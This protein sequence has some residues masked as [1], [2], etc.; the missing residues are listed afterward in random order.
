MS[1]L[2]R[3]EKIDSV[4]SN[5]AHTVSVIVVATSHEIEDY[6]HIAMR[7]YGKEV[8]WRDINNKSA[9]C[10]FLSLPDKVS[11]THSFRCYKIIA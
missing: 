3:V 7:Q 4:K 6:F 8:F 9:L 1:A 10:I 11:I 5:S 2:Y